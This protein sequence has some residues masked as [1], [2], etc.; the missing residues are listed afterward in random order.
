MKKTLQERDITVALDEL[1]A[2]S[3]WLLS[4]DERQAYLTSLLPLIPHETDDARLLAIICNY[5]QDHELDRKSV[6]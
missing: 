5:H 6:V 3:G 1:N 4:A 2:E